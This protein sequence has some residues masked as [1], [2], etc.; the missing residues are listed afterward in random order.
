MERLHVSA[1]G[2][3]QKRPYNDVFG[4]QNKTP[5]NSMETPSYEG[6]YSDS[7]RIVIHDMDQFLRESSDEVDSLSNQVKDTVGEKIEDFENVDLEK[8]VIPDLDSNSRLREYIAKILVHKR[9]REGE[10]GEIE[11]GERNF[12]LNQFIKRYMALI[13]Y[14]NPGLLVWRIYMRWFE[15]NRDNSAGKIVE[16]D[17]DGDEEML[18]DDETEIMADLAKNDDAMS[19][20]NVV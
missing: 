9:E 13:R 11:A 8:L 4:V 2:S 10:T 3:S 15:E 1:G 14:Y 12:Y 17:D 19:I 16:L 7:D 18:S 6:Y 20:D 5:I